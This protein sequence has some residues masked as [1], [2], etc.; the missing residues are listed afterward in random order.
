VTA[1]NI[2]V[3][4]GAPGLL[5]ILENSVV[6]SPT[7]TVRAE[8]LL[9]GDVTV[10]AK[11]AKGEDTPNLVGD[12]VVEEGGRV[13]VSAGSAPAI[14]VSGNATLNGTLEVA[15]VDE[16][17]LAA[18]M[19]LNLLHVDGTTTGDFTEVTFPTRSAEFDGDISVEDGTLV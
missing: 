3:G 10:P 5:A 6:T 14:R 8:G 19:T 17:G 12:L 13:R 9:I 4:G 11:L 18:G 16:A 7:T 1:G 2:I 15:F